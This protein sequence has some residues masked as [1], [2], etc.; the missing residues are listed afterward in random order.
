MSRH[1]GRDEDKPYDRIDL[2]LRYE[3]A[4]RT[5]ELAYQSMDAVDIDDENKAHRILRY[6]ATLKAR[7]EQIEALVMA[8]RAYM[9]WEP[10]TTV[11]GDYRTLMFR[12]AELAIKEANDG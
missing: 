10:A 9:N 3:W 7:D 12:A 1:T 6:A 11:A 5:M 4:R 8:L 2:D